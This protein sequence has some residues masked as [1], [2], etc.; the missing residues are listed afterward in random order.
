[1]SNY[2]A[3]WFSKNIPTWTKL[4]ADLK[5]SP[6]NILE[7]G[8]FEGRA[9]VWLLETLP[10]CRI[11]AIDPFVET[12][13]YKKYGGYDHNYEQ[14]F[15]ENVRPYGIRV[16][17]IKGNSFDWLRDLSKMPR[18]DLVYVDG[19]HQAVSVLQDIVLSW[20]MLKE[21]GIMICDDYEWGM[22]DDRPRIAI[23]AFMNVYKGKYTVINKGY[24]I[25][26]K[27]L[28]RVAQ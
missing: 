8:C 7:I 14:L 1:V 13:E 23:D 28:P 26:F 11:T 3:D 19:S 10:E 25:A 27:K 22:A 5:S 21:G 6:L 15:R 12:E 2:T 4:L 17:I 20:E 18:Y 9:T 24:Q 16:E